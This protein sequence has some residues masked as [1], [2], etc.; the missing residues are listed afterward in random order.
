MHSHFSVDSN[1]PAEVAKVLSN[2]KNKELTDKFKD[3]AKKPQP[4]K[5]Q[6]AEKQKHKLAIK[7]QLDY[8]IYSQFSPP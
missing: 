1:V 5:K 3:P 6:R 8:I 4:N 2:A 7:Q